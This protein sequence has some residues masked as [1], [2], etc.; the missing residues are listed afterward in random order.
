VCAFALGARCYPDLAAFHRAKPGPVFPAFAAQGWVE[1]QEARREARSE[2]EPP[3]VTDHCVAIFSGAIRVSET[4]INTHSGLEF[5]H[6]LVDI[7]SGTADVVAEPGLIDGD[8]S[9]GSIIHGR[10]VIAAAIPEAAS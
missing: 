9:P 10:F 7:R 2:T 5:Q 8:A 4:L 6:L 1:L 3:M